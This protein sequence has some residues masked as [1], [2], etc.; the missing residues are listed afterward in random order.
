MRPTK[1]NE[2]EQRGKNLGI[3]LFES[4]NSN[5]NNNNNSNGNEHNEAHYEMDLTKTHE[6]INKRINEHAR[7]TGYVKPLTFL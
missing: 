7:R 6:P 5:S 4:Y 3:V 2:T 1:T